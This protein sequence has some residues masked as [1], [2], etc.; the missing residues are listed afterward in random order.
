MYSFRS[1]I[2]SHIITDVV[3]G[4]G[5]ITLDRPAALNAL[6]LNMIRD[7]TRTLNDWRDD[8]AIKAVAVRGSDK[9][10]PFGGFCAGGDIRF[11]H[12]AG[13]SDDPNLEAFFYRRI[14]IKLFNF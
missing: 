2:L 11:F 14:S 9:N 6:N 5:L 7:L 3:A 12:A 4:V 8:P 10:G 1:I 13:M